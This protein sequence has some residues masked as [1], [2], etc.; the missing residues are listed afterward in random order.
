MNRRRLLAAIGSIGTTGIAG[1]L[2]GDAGTA[3]PGATTAGGDDSAACVPSETASVRE[4]LPPGGEFERT[5]LVSSGLDL[6]AEEYVLARYTAPGGGSV[7]L[8]VAA[9]G[10]PGAARTGAARIRS[11]STKPETGT[12]VSGSY[13]VAVDAPSRSVAR[14]LV[15]ASGVAD[16]C[17]SALSFAPAGTPTTADAEPGSAATTAPATTVPS[18]DTTNTPTTSTPEPVVSSFSDDW[19]DGD[20]S[21]DPTWFVEQNARDSAVEVTDV[22]SPGGSKALRMTGRR[23]NVRAETGESLRY[24]APWTMDL[25]FRAAASARSSLKLRFGSGGSGMF[26]ANSNFTL[27]ISLGKDGSDT[28]RRATVTLSG[29]RID[30]ANTLKPVLQVGTWYRVRVRHEGGGSYR[31]LFW[32]ATDDRETADVAPARGSAPKTGPDKRLPLR[33]V[34]RSPNDRN[35]DAAEFLLDS[36]AYAT[37]AATSG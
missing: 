33:I 19:E 18:T 31:L 37:D 23:G 2:G 16:G 24:D 13:V 28:Q 14:S 36:F 7:D 5:R 3:T 34:A 20:Y 10:S 4:L 25:L 30:D 8:I 12:L 35:I 9:Y 15:G 22:Q 32:P 27:G 11:M 6:G 26:S 21:Q 29:S 17:A 1:C